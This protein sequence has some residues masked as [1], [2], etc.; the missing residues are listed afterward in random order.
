MGLVVKWIPGEKEAIFSEKIVFRGGKE[1]ILSMR[2]FRHDRHCRLK[3]LSF[4]RVQGGMIEGAITETTFLSK[5]NEQI[6]MDSMCLWRQFNL[7]GMAVYFLQMVYSF[8][9]RSISKFFFILL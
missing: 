6:F 2:I 7:S 4:I 3:F 9:F 1:D 8:K 5:R